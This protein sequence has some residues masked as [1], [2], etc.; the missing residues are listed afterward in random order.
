MADQHVF[1][2]ASILVSDQQTDQ[3]L[4][5]RDLDGDGPAAKGDEITVFFDSDNQSG[6]VTPTANVFSLHQG[7]DG[8]V[9]VGDGH[10]DS[11][12]RLVDRNGDFDAQDADEAHVWFSAENAGA[13]P[14]VTPNGLWQG[15]DGALYV[16]NAGTPVEP[17]DAIYRTV[18]LN[19]DGDANDA[20]EAVQWL[21]LNETGTAEVP[22]AIGFDGDV[23]YVND[24]AGVA[25]RSIYRIQDQDNNGTITAA[26]ATAFIAAD[27]TFSSDLNVA[28]LTVADGAI[29]ALSWHPQLGNILRLY[30]LEDQNGS[31][32]IDQAEEA[33]EVWNSLTLP[34]DSDA[35]IAY[36]VAADMSGNLTI[37]ANGFSGTASV[38]R[39]SDENGDGDYMDFAET[40]LFSSSTS[41]D[42]L[43]KPRAVEFY[44]STTPFVAGAEQIPA[45]DGFLV[46]ALALILQRFLPV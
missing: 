6:L 19:G 1:G 31:G 8:S 32:L 43:A 45:D 33:T 41:T 7:L 16:S 17:S 44:E 13:L 26:E 42:Q 38:L 46:L 35:H 36:S 24:L 20:G 9:F 11:I 40:I 3:V 37:S 22:F 10:S 25:A 14:F 15:A 30:R 12:Y 27:M 23:A 18:D 5:L 4:L 39:L 2:P 21:D 29:Y 34:S 28:S